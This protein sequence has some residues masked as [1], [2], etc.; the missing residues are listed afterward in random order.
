VVE[1]YARTEHAN[2]LYYLM[3]GL[4]GLTGWCPGSGA[5]WC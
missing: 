4:H 5:R 1:L 3:F 2:G